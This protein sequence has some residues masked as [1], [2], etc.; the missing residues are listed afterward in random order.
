MFP[1]YLIH[2]CLHDSLVPASTHILCNALMLCS[3]LSSLSGYMAMRAV[4]RLGVSLLHLLNLVFFFS[5][6]CGKLIFITAPFSGFFWFFL[7]TS[8]A[9]PWMQ[10]PAIQHTHA[11][12]HTYTPPTQKT[13]LIQ[14]Y[15][16]HHKDAYTHS[17]APSLRSRAEPHL[18]GAVQRIGR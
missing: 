10:V 2:R 16:H 18:C 13:Y 15:T 8:I 6:S 7:L 17:N 5:I 12:T 3:C 14:T 4:L 9:Q 11:R 1:V